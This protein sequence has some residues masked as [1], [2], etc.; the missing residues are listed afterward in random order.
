[1]KPEA[2]P[3]SDIP[4]AS[5]EFRLLHEALLQLKSKYRTAI[6]LRYFEGRTIA[7][8]AEITGRKEG[9]LRCQLHRGLA[10]ITGYPF[11]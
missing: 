10:P 4:T 8:I 1:M 9:T 3:A 2:P 7:E 6:T 5:E 11:T